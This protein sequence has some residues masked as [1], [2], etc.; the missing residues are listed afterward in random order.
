[1][2]KLRGIKQ[3][4][5]SPDWWSDDVDENETKEVTADL[6]KEIMP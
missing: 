3:S 1:M 4:K 2:E 5:W 6:S